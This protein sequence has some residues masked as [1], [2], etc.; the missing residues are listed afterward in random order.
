MVL[1]AT[2]NAPGTCHAPRGSPVCSVAFSPDGQKL[3][4][5]SDDGTAKVW[6]MVSG[7]ELLTLKGHSLRVQWVADS[8][9]DV[10]A[11]AFTPD[12]VHWVAFSPDGQ[13]IAASGGP[14]VKVWDAASGKELLVMKKERAEM[15]SVAFSPDGRRIVTGSYDGVATVWDAASGQPPLSLQG[16]TGPISNV[17]FSPNSQQIF[18]ASPR[19]GMVKVWETASGQQ[20]LSLVAPDNRCVAFS[21][22]GQRILTGNVWG[23]LQVWDAA[24]GKELLN[25]ATHGGPIRAVAFSPDGQ[26]IVTC[27]VDMVAKIWDAASG[28]HRFSLKGH[29]D[30]MGSVAFSPDSQRIVTGGGDMTAKV[31][32]A[33][34][35]AEALT[36]FGGWAA[37]FSPDGQHIARAARKVRPG[38]GRRAAARKSLHLEGT[39][40]GSYQP[41]FLRT[42][43][44]SSREAVTRPPGCGTWPAAKRYTS[45]GDTGAWS[46]QWLFLPMVT[47]L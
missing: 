35:G 3:V 5:G 15:L 21:L 9:D 40:T 16:H 25:A 14:E 26:R 38:S 39:R 46:T 31:W 6:E 22:D 33:D 30:A 2:A 42:V 10:R 43:S 1:L 11:E 20:L 44:R 17:A 29:G 24:S 41:P 19:T 36:F 23:A 4:T 45:S 13:R 27:G 37:S 28:G 12:D 32:K 18:T 34:R 7:K 47:G 8:P